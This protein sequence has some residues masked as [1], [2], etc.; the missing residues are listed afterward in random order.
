MRA[1]RGCSRLITMHAV[2][3]RWRAAGGVAG[4]H[5]AAS[6]GPLG[7]TAQ[8]ALGSAGGRR[9][10]GATARTGPGVAQTGTAGAEIRGTWAWEHAD[11]NSDGGRTDRCDGG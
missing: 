8:R 5:M 10:S 9:T 11:G 4:A 7:D 3:I 1:R 6:A 2:G